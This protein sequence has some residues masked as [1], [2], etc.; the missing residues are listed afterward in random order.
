MALIQ[1]GSP[2]MMRSEKNNLYT[3]LPVT[4]PSPKIA[5]TSTKM[6]TFDLILNSQI[7]EFNIPFALSSIKS[8]DTGNNAVAILLNNGALWLYDYSGNPI[9]QIAHSAKQMQFSDDNTKLMY[10]DND[11]KTF[12]YLMEDDLADLNSTKGQSIRLGLVDSQN[13]RSIW[14]FPDSF[15]LILQYPD[16]IAVAEVTTSEPNNQ[17]NIAKNQGS[18]FYDSPS[19]NLYLLSNETLTVYNIGSL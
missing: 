19:K 8:F 7:S 18:T 16:K 3:L 4:P 9:T 2:A 6:E 17:F 15:H 1:D 11:G 10:Q 13:I 12:V 14:W 5:S